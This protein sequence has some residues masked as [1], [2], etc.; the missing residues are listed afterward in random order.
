MAAKL[1]WETYKSAPSDQLKKE[2]ILSY[3]PLV[4]Y[5]I[6]RKTLMFE[7]YSRGILQ[8]EDW[9]QFGIEGLNEAIDRFDITRGIKFETY[10]ILRIKGKIIDNLRKL[11]VKPTQYTQSLQT[12]YT[13]VK[14][15]TVSLN[16][17][18]S[19]TED[20]TLLD[21][22]ENPNADDPFL[23]VELDN[24]RDEV[25]V[26]IRELEDKDRL[27]LIW[28]YYEGLSYK[29]IGNILNVT[30]SRVSQIHTQ[31]IKKLKLKLAYLQSA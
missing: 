1:Q 30:V 2:I 24:I 27:V 17:F 28:Y 4:N 19:D 26:V 6:N 31:I 9:V 22:L 8:R 11:E 25:K 20:L 13:P 10:A 18:V 3:L 23:K 5:V 7:V 29:E 15:S 16:T 14:Y 21:V 12:T